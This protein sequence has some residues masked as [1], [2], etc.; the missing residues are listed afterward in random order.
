MSSSY[1]LEPPTRGK[2]LLRTTHGDLELELF[3]KESPKTCRAF[4]QMCLE[5]FW[6][7]PGGVPFG[8]VIAGLMVETAAPAAAVAGAAGTVVRAGKRRR[9]KVQGRG[10]GERRK[11]RFSTTGRQR[12]GVR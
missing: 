7:A 2:V 5:G 8:R 3:A 4:V 1:V 12:P 9:G 6:D 11:N 10:E